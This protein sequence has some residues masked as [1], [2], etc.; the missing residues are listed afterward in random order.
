LATASLDVIRRQDFG[1]NPQPTALLYLLLRHSMMLA[2]WDAGTRFLEERGLV[3]SVVARAEPAFI[4]VQAA[5]AGGQ[6]KFQNLYQPQPA[7]TGSATQTLAEYVLSPGVLGIAPETEPLSEMIA[8]LNVL[9]GSPTARLERGFAEHIDCCS[10][11][12]DAWKT[13]LATVRLAEMRGNADSK[14]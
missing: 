14:E 2:Q 8:A 3:N 11:R 1:G 5:A 4:N 12:L 10:Y 13:G 6:S 9:A 7:I